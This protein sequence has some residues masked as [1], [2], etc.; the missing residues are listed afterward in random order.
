MAETTERFPLQPP[1]TVTDTASIPLIESPA[2]VMVEF[3]I[4]K[5]C[6]GVP[7]S[8][9]ATVPLLAVMEEPEILPDPTVEIDTPSAAVMVELETELLLAPAEMVTPLPAFRMEPCATET[10]PCGAETEMFPPAVRVT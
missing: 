8:M 9:R 6:P 7:A 1:C 10:Y 4:A 3:E 2:E 5:L